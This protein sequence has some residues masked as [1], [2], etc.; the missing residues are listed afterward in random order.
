MLVSHLTIPTM[1]DC[2]FMS[3][4]IP[5]ITSSQPRDDNWNLSHCLYFTLASTQ[6]L[7]SWRQLWYT[8]LGTGC[9]HSSA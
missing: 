5:V 7:I 2:D 1:L 3:R 8:A 6:Q 4:S 9:T